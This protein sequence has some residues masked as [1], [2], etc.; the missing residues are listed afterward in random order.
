[1]GH[2][3]AGEPQDGRLIPVLPQLIGLTGGG[4]T[5][6]H[7]GIDVT[8]LMIDLAREREGGDDSVDELGPWSD[9]VVLVEETTHIAGGSVAYGSDVDERY[10]GNHTIDAAID[11]C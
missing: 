1:I 5:V 4:E 10:A 7:A 6:R 3:G 9:Q 11:S 8:G 2:M